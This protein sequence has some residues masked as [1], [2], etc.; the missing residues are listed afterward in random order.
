M[1]FI[2][3]LKFDEN[4]LIP[5][6]IQDEKTCEVLMMAYMNKLAL[7]K[8]INSGTTHFYSRKRKKIW[9]KGEIS[10]HTQEVKEI[11]LDCDNDCILI[12]VKQKI[13]ACHN[14]YKTCFY[15]KLERD[16]KIKV[17]FKK[18]FEPKD[19]HGEKK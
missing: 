4:G 3:E 13:A 12:K 17:V 10:G 9:K 7:K 16:G 2:K 18:V 11:F 14:G 8:T 15:R 19:I 1:Q 6:I 5:V